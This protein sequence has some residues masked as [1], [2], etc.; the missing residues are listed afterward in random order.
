[1][2]LAAN[3]KPTFA[4]APTPPEFA[5]TPDREEERADLHPQNPV[6]VNDAEAA[7]AAPARDEEDED[8]PDFSAVENTRAPSSSSSSSAEREAPA[9][10]DVVHLP[11]NDTQSSSSS[12]SNKVGVIEVEQTAQPAPPPPSTSSWSPSAG[13]SKAFLHFYPEAR[14]AIGVVEAPHLEE[15]TAANGEQVVQEEKYQSGGDAEDSS[16]GLLVG[17]QEPAPFPPSEEQEVTRA[18]PAEETELPSTS[19]KILSRKI[20]AGMCAARGSLLARGE[21]EGAELEQTR[22]RQQ[23]LVVEIQAGREHEEVVDE[24]EDYDAHDHDEEK[25]RPPEESDDCPSAEQQSPSPVPQTRCSPGAPS[26]LVRVD[27]AQQH[28]ELELQVEEAVAELEQKEQI[29]A[30]EEEEEV[31]EAVV[32]GADDFDDDVDHIED[33]DDAE[34]KMLQLQAQSP[35]DGASPSATA[36]RAFLAATAAAAPPPEVE[37]N[38]EEDLFV[39]LPV[40]AKTPDDNGSSH[41]PPE[42]ADDRRTPPG[43]PLDAQPPRFE[44]QGS[45]A[46]SASADQHPHSSLYPP[47]VELEPVVQHKLQAQPPG[48]ASSSTVM[49]YSDASNHPHPRAAPGAAQLQSI[50]AIDALAPEAFT[51]PVVAPPQAASVVS[52]APTM[53][54]VPGLLPA[55]RPPIARKSV[56]SPLTLAVPELGSGGGATDGSDMEEKMILAP[57]PAA[58]AIEA[59]AETSIAPQ[60]VRTQSACSEG[61]RRHDLHRQGNHDV[62]KNAPRL[63]PALHQ[64]QQKPPYFTTRSP[65]TALRDWLVNP[66]CVLLAGFSQDE[67]D[68]AYFYGDTQIELECRVFT[69]RA[70]A[71]MEKK[72][73]IL[74][75]RIHC[76]TARHNMALQDDCGHFCDVVSGFEPLEVVVRKVHILDKL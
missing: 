62:M 14:M 37:E 11:F 4:F 50:G 43:G 8:E 58:L 56:G 7:A 35:D 51:S 16:P 70:S 34:H 22:R 72:Q 32:V 57:P 29:A 1:M 25:R 33:V 38:Q 24:E 59:V 28:E 17:V 60:T 30:E 45:S 53:L 75:G 71:G 2:S 55:Q 13:G 10:S 63:I 65:T 26:P 49:F 47:A 15:E 67:R 20:A 9:A 54:A 41:Q 73:E 74:L 40:P 52:L 6:V 68:G 69:G 36:P 19:R 39:S 27:N 42:Q 44:Q 31:L 66:G 46:S 5:S 3:A 61:A 76:D 64:D 21:A 23:Q 18:S 12:S 48:I